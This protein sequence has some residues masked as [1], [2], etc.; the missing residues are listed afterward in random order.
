MIVIDIIVMKST[1][2]DIFVKDSHTE[3]CKNST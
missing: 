1:L 2:A 3:F